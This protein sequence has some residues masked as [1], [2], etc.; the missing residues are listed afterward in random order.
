MKLS[1]ILAEGLEQDYYVKKTTPAEVK[2]F[3]RIF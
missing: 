2:W 1:T 3:F